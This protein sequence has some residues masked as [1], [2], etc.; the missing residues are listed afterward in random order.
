MWT[1]LKRA[2]LFSLLLTLPA[3]SQTITGTVLDEKG[4][5]VQGAEISTNKSK[6]ITDVDGRFTLPDQAGPITLKI[7]GPYITPEQKILTADDAR[8]N[9]EI[10]IHYTIGKQHESLVITAT[11]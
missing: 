1:Q 11:A 4:Q 8:Q 10:R 3:W 5:L 9:L 6:T 7:T 2:F